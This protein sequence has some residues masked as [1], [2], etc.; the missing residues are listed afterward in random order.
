M[1]LVQL[2]LP[3]FDN[4]GNQFSKEDFSEVRKCLLDKFGGLTIY[5]RNAATGLWKDSAGEVDTDEVIIFEVM[6]K[7]MNR[8]WW[9]RYRPQ[10][11]EKF[12]QE[13]I[14]IRFS[15]FEKL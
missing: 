12:Q 13:E 5:R 7:S 3:L 10:L 11:E 9:K 14:L 15:V 4:Q 2:F 8:K 1:I 6:T